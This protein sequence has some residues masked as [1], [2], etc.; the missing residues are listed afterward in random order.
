MALTNYRDLSTSSSDVA[1]GFQFEFYC[2]AC[3]ET[4]RSAFQPYRK[5]QLTGWLNRFTFLLGDLHK[6]SRASGAFADAG[7]AGA[8]ADALAEA[9]SAVAALYQHCDRCRKWVGRECWNERTDSCKTC[10]Q[11][12]GAAAPGQ[13]GA[14]AP[15]Q[16]G[17]AC[18]N[19]QAPSQGGRFCP[20]CGFD[21]AS[22]HK[23]CPGCG[24]LQLRQAR[25]CTDCGHGF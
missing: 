14:L 4:Q 23:S 21:M 15:G 18:P 8:K 1:A 20:E 3:G 12:A 9:T 2:E 5:G 7:A 11:G 22:T 6:A 17:S 25:F 10:A 24:A 19:C 16:A 13:G